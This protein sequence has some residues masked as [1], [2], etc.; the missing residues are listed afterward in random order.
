MKN[1]ILFLLL[2]TSLTISYSQAL[3]LRAT[4]FSMK[5]QGGSWSDWEDSEMLIVIKDDRVTIY[6]NEQQE[7][8]IVRSYDV[9]TD[10]DGDNVLK[11]KCVDQ[12]GDL[13]HLRVI[14]RQS[15]TVQLYIDFSNVS[16]VYNVRKI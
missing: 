6:S 1:S 9:Y 8:D 4:D 10:S 2:F 16:W 15:G 14:S 13:C 11:F 12:D 7:Y 5:L 3:K